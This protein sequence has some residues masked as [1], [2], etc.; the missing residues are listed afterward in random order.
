[1]VTRE[2]DTGDGEHGFRSAEQAG[3][4][5]DTAHGGGILVVH[6]PFQQ[7]RCLHSSHSVGAMIGQPTD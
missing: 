2:P 7:L 5:C 4:P 6:F 3:M 1:M